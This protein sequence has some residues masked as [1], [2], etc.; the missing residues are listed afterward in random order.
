MNRRPG[1]PGLIRR[2][3]DRM[4]LE[5][6]LAAGPLTRVRISGQTGLSKVTVSHVI[7]RLEQAGLI[8]AVGEQT[9]GRGPSA[10]LYGVVPS[11]A[12]VAGLDVHLNT[13]AVAIADVTGTVVGE[14]TAAL[15]TAG[16]PVTIVRDVIAETCGAAG[17]PLSQLRAFVIGTQGIIEPD[18]GDVR[19]AFNLPAWQSGVRKALETELGR[20]VTLENDVNLAAMTERQTGAARDAGDFVLM[21]LDGGL[22]MGVMLGDRIHR[23]ALGG[24]GEIG[25][26]PVPG[27]ELPHIVTEPRN[28]SHETIGGALQSLINMSAV[29]ELARAHGFTQDSAVA[30]LTAARA[31]AD[32]DGAPFLDALSSRIALGVASVCAVVDPDLVVLAGPV[33]RAGGTELATRV[34]RAIRP[35]CPARPRVAASEVRGNA[36]LSGAL[37]AA[38][39]QVHT[40][41][42]SDDDG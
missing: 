4:V 10:V 15:D 20:P 7:G 8:T 42:C 35:I 22:G 17:I 23:G 28:T 25:Y 11:C 38:L 2:I 1:T 33:G 18:S 6:L 16:D 24:A 12:Y 21:W 39:R 41:I 29:H 30:C 14:T 31:V 36:V 37:V 3:N 5:L 26:L 32:G 40:S 9:G 27:A 19:F 13:V 34:E